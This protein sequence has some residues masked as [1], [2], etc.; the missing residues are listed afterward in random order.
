MFL[1]KQL[2]LGVSKKLIRDSDE[3]LG[4]VESMRIDKAVAQWLKR[5]RAFSLCG[6]WLNAEDNSSTNWDI[7]YLLTICI[8]IFKHTCL[9]C[10]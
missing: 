5:L 2:L 6:L 8:W 10:C 3:Q 4:S 7:S 9:K 1:N